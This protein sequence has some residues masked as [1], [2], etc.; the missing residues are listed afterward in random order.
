MTINEQVLQFARDS[1]Y[2]GKEIKSFCIMCN[3]NISFVHNNE[4]HVF[5]ITFVFF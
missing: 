3:D 4:K 1:G 5:F 2:D